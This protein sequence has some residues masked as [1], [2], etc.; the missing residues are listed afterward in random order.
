[1]QR[2]KCAQDRRLTKTA[3]ELVQKLHLCDRQ[4]DEITSQKKTIQF[5]RDSLITTIGDGVE[6]EQ[7]EPQQENAAPSGLMLG[8]E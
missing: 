6:M 1:M 7:E 4:R 3:A 8:A 2:Y 5:L